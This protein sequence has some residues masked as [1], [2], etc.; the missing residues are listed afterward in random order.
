M[1]LN[2]TRVFK[3]RADLSGSD[4][5]VAMRFA[6]DI[7]RKGGLVAFPTETVYGLGANALDERAVHGIFEAKGRPQDNPLIVH[8]SSYEDMNKYCDTN[9]EY[10]PKLYPLMPG[11]ITVVLPKK[12]IIPDSVCAGNKTV[13]IRIPQ[14]LVARRLIELSGVPVA[15]P[16]ANIS[17]KPS[18]TSASHV[19]SDLS[20]KV[21]VIIDCGS[22]TV[23]VE[24]TVLSLCTP[25]PVILRPGGITFESLLKL[26]GKVELASSITAPLKEGEKVAAPG[27]KYKHYAPN[28]PVYLLEGSET[29]I[30]TFMRVKDQRENCAI[31]C[32]D[33]DMPLV[34]GK[35]MFSVGSFESPE[36]YARNLF[37]ALRKTD[38]IEGLCAIYARIPKN[39]EGISL[40]VYN[41][42]LKASGFCKID[43]MDFKSTTVIIGLTG[44]TGGGKGVFC[45]SAQKM[46]CVCID[47]DKIGHEIMQKDGPAYS[48]LIEAFGRKVLD[49]QKN[50]CRKKLAEV[51]FS[52]KEE[53]KKLNKITHKHISKEV[54]KI[55]KECESNNINMVIVDAPVL[56]ESDISLICNCTV[57]VLANEKVRK[58]RIIQRDNINEKAAN[59]RMENARDDNY[60]ISK[61]DY[62]IRNNGSAEQFCTEVQA[63]VEKIRNES[64]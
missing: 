26:L 15:A 10:L 6:A 28:T 24:S 55:I 3:V 9:N 64:Q 48:E 25:V 56:F 37:D 60:F 46:G 20:G 36:V 42:L 27:M 4:D 38:E 40:A 31:L 19:I 61:C 53:L 13:G 43:T 49:A 1:I 23:G 45:A 47:T 62:V 58:E 34:C 12:D 29:S 41:R 52:S 5:M 21:D 30:L 17:G 57:A 44:P 51:V 22:T 59:V 33:E 35:N 11:P 63:L 14:S 8:L 50:I 54:C 7:L 16:S 18:P 39:T 32:Y 2:T